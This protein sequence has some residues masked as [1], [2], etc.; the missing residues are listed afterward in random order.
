MK[1]HVLP[2]DAYLDSFRGTDLEGD[3]VVFRECLVEGELWGPSLPEFWKTRETYLSKTYPDNN[4]SYKRD[5]AAEIEKLFVPGAADEIY[6]WFEYELFCGVNYWFC[7]YLLRDSLATIYRV[8]P[9]V[10]GQETRWRGF[11]RLSSEEL[12]E[13]WADRVRLVR[14]DVERG[15]ELWLAFKTGNKHRLEAL[16]THESEAFPYLREVSAAAADAKTRP[17]EILAEISPTG[18][19]EFREIFVEFGKRA[20]VYGLGDEQVKRL[21]DEIERAA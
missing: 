1:L 21:L 12:N 11:G 15:T 6:L 3:I 8:S 9:A 19:G 20:G 10:R 17:R 7:L 13:C 16:G 2:G 5:V 18:T 4:K 14:E